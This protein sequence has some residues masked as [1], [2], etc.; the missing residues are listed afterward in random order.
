MNTISVSEGISYGF[1]MMIYYVAVVVVGQIATFIGF[2]MF[3]AGME[4]GFGQ[5]PSWGLVL[6]GV[7]FILA[8]VVVVMAGIFGAVYKLIG[9]AVAKGRV[10]SPQIE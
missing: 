2:A 8:G 10:M 3:S 9:D 4:T 1:R 7:L 6:F 5:D